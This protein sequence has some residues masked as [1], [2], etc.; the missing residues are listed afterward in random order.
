MGTIVGKL[1][2]IV[3]HRICLELKK[4]VVFTTKQELIYPQR[5]LQQNKC[6]FDLQSWGNINMDLVK[7]KAKCLQPC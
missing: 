2:L 7:N 4:N 1:V 6:S 3:A 5:S